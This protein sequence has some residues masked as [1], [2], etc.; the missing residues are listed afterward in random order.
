MG[1]GGGGAKEF[2]HTK[3]ELN[4]RQE[5]KEIER[6]TNISDA[7]VWKFDSRLGFRFFQAK[8]LV[9]VFCFKKIHCFLKKFNLKNGFKSFCSCQTKHYLL[10]KKKFINRRPVFIKEN[11]FGLAFFGQTQKNLVF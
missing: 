4:I 8:T 9:S 5:T 7:K 11:T 6:I 10:K 1:W 3:S 2:R